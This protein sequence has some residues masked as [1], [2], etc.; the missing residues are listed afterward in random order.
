MRNKDFIFTVGYQG[1]TAI[2][3]ARAQA[4]YQKFSTAELAEKGLFKQAIC[5]ALAHHSA[6][7]LEQVLVIYNRQAAAPVASVAVL[8]RMYGVHEMPQGIEKVLYI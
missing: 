2:V 4:Q 1:N 6:E 5:S 7:E 8:Q 3:D